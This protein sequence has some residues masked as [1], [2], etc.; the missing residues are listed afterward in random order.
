MVENKEINLSEGTSFS[1]KPEL[2]DSLHWKNSANVLCN[3]MKK[4]EYLDLIL[5]N[6]A[7]IPRYYE[8]PLDYLHLE[9]VDKIC[10]PM[11]CFCDI[12]FSKVSSH[13]HYYG[14]YGIGLDKAAVLEK[15]RVQPIHYINS[16]SP[17][18]DDFR[19]AFHVS[20][21]QKMDGEAVVLADYLLSSLM[22]MKPVWGWEK[23]EDGDM[24]MRV[25]QDECE[26][27]YVP[28]D[29]F[30]E[31]L[32]LILRQWEMTQKGKETYTNVLYHHKECWL[33]FDWS[34]VHYIIV[35]DEFAA[36]HTISTV[37]GLEN[38]SLG[39]KDELISRIEISSR[40]AE[41]M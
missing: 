14:S 8:E 10:F 21:R 7:I 24:E 1:G 15:Y 16:D 20:C 23:K 13:M 27:R 39:V 40:F 11:T 3:Y 4:P 37:R 34:D 17:L 26:W 6:Q 35:P 36:R 41:N 9:N 5:R 33:K 2:G 32:P 38:V 30:P 29:H 18:A 25:Y 28:S 22:Y 19:Q 12:P 31:N